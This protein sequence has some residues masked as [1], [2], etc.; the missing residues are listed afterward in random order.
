MTD[1]TE[2]LL[3]GETW[4]DD[5]LFNQNRTQTESSRPVWKLDSCW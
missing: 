1:R 4:D 3:I 2:I 5:V